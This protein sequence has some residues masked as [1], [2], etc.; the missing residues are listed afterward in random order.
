MNYPA[1]NTLKYPRHWFSR[2]VIHH[3]VSWIIFHEHFIGCGYLMH[4]R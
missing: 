2:I 1:Y 4:V 3:K